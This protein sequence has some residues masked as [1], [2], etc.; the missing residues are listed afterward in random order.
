MHWI[1]QLFLLDN[2]SV[3]LGFLFKLKDSSSLETEALVMWSCICMNWTAVSRASNGTPKLF[4]VNVT[5]NLLLV[6]CQYWIALCLSDKWSFG[7][8]LFVISP[9]KSLHKQGRLHRQS[10]LESWSIFFLVCWDV[11]R[12]LPLSVFVYQRSMK[13]TILN[14]NKLGN[15]RGHAPRYISY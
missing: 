8:T 14:L 7:D 13:H 11:F 6:S 1:G 9:V 3:R 10:L 12:L 4:H 15:F 5:I 2:I